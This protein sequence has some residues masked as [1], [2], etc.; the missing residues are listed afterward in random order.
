MIIMY[1]VGGWRQRL[2]ACGFYT[3]TSGGMLLARP[4]CTVAAAWRSCGMSRPK[5]AHVSRQE[6][7]RNEH[8]LVRPNV[9]LAD[10]EPK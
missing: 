2:A 3:A 4:M 7:K 1:G 8:A 10:Y 9:K 5:C 6:R